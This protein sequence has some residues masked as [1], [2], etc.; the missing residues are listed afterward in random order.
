LVLAGADQ[1]AGRNI[2]QA[3]KFN[4]QI[5]DE[6]KKPEIG[7]GPEPDKLDQNAARHR[8]RRQC[9]DQIDREREIKKQ[10]EGDG[11]NEESQGGI[12]MQMLGSDA[13]I[14]PAARRACAP[15]RKDI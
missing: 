3:D 5:A 14:R 4:A 7:V 6:S 12:P 13:A 1:R 9:D 10:V 2:L 11:A 8:Q 15:P